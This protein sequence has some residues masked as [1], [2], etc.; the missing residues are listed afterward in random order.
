VSIS[1][2]SE[3]YFDTIITKSSG[4][5]SN[6]SST[7]TPLGKPQLTRRWNR[8]DEC[9]FFLHN[10]EADEGSALLE[11]VLRGDTISLDIESNRV[12]LG[13]ILEKKTIYTEG[14][15]M[16][17]IY[18]R[19][20]LLNA[21][22]QQ[23]NR[24]LYNGFVGKGRSFVNTSFETDFSFLGPTGVSL[25]ERF[26]D[27]HGFPDINQ[28]TAA[29]NEIG[30]ISNDGT[31]DRRLA[32]IF[33]PRSNTITGVYLPLWDASDASAP[34]NP[35][36]IDANIVVAWE[37]TTESGGIQ[38]PSGTA[39]GTVD[40][41][42]SSRVFSPGFKE[43]WQ[44]AS[45]T[46][47]TSGPITGSDITW[48]VARTGASSAGNVRAGGTSAAF[49]FG[50][51]GAYFEL[52][53]VSTDSVSITT[54]TPGGILET[55]QPDSGWV[56]FQIKPSNTAVAGKIEIE[57]DDG[58]TNTIIA[59]VDIQNGSVF[60]YDGEEGDTGNDIRTAMSGVSYTNGDELFIFFRIHLESLRYDVYFMDEVTDPGAVLKAENIDF[61]NRDN[62]GAADLQIDTYRIEAS[63]SSG[64][65]DV[66]WVSGN[67]IPMF[68]TGYFLPGGRWAYLS[69]LD[70]PIPVTPGRSYA[71]TIRAN[72]S[73]DN[74]RNKA[75]IWR[76]VLNIQDVSFDFLRSSDGGTTWVDTNPA[77]SDQIPPYGFIIEYGNSWRE[78][79]P[80]TD[81]VID[82]TNEKL[83]WQD[84]SQIVG[85]ADDRFR[86]QTDPTTK[87]SGAG[88]FRSIRFNTF[89]NRS[90]AKYG[91]IT[92]TVHPGLAFAQRHA[93]TVA[94]VVKN[95]ASF[96]DDWGTIT[97]D[98]TGSGTDDGFGTSAEGFHDD[99]GDFK[100]DKFAIRQRRII[101]ALRDLADQHGAIITISVDGSA[102]FLFEIIKTIASATNNP[103]SSN[104]AT[105]EYVVTN[106]TDLLA[107][108]DAVRLLQNK[109]QRNETETFTDFIVKGD[110][111]TLVAKFT[112]WELAAALRTEGNPLHLFR[113]PVVF[114]KIVDY[115]ELFRYASALNDVFGFQ[116]REGTITVSGF[117]PTHTDN[118]LDINGIMRV[119]DPEMEDGSDVTG[120]DN[121]F[122]IA[123]LAYDGIRNRTTIRLNNHPIDLSRL[124]ERLKEQA[125][126]LNGIDPENVDFDI[127]ESNVVIESATITASNEH[128]LALLLD[129]DVE[130]NSL[131]D[132]YRRVNAHQ[133]RKVIDGTTYYHFTGYF[134][135]QTTTIFNDL[136]PVK[137]VALYTVKT[138]GSAVATTTN[139][140]LGDSIFV[141]RGMGLLFTFAIKAV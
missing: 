135:P 32:I 64:L 56:C 61:I 17:E 22:R 137:K 115:D 75:F 46:G 131:N 125:D 21:A 67:E 114:K 101:D 79:I 24:V 71:L 11:E 117:F 74:T 108:D 72:A 89:L 95:I 90:S 109:I 86:M 118:R 129:G 19:D 96:V 78:Q 50:W 69:Y 73:I 7:L 127:R 65:I 123:E 91:I 94:D 43:S 38:E 47:I 136:F 60:Y 39:I 44:G 40:G 2:P 110:D 4:T 6:G 103:S 70:D 106:D 83:V 5:Y 88:N 62:L 111:E 35:N 85:I 9:V 119:I 130:M 33:K 49:S 132:N 139:F 102:N 104:P 18:A 16:Y 76:Q 112:N 13:E 12:F 68:G 100:V 28:E 52:N 81:F 26:D 29:T 122:K 99:S 1:T 98:G 20:P 92:A 51:G 55:L 63:T 37:T 116:R 3:D 84:G 107:D 133:F 124:E 128:Y 15:H 36:P 138:G 34:A 41:A 77:S 120:T 10:V 14:T 48:E 42:S 66:G 126:N 23:L 87:G 97:V 25:V 8:S 45:G 140:E 58:S 27:P 121:V 80:G 30:E 31:T 141:W 82:S 59:R 93:M 113:D 57:V 53:N 54:S 134:P 105:H